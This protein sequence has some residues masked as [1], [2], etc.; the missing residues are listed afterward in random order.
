M[1]QEV[2]SKSSD[3]IILERCLFALV[4]SALLSEN[5]MTLLVLVLNRQMRMVPNMFEASLTVSDFRVREFFQTF[6][7]SIREY[8]QNG[9]LAMQRADFKAFYHQ[10]WH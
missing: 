8:F 3:T 5:F 6:Y 9:L 4:L 10:L 7:R 1:L 2:K